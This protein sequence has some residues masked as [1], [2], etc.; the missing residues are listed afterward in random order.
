[1]LEKFNILVVDDYLDNRYL[2]SQFLD[3]I[4]VKHSE[5]TN[6][7]ECLEKLKSQQFDLIFMDIEMPV[8]NG[9]ETTRYIRENF[10]GM[11][12]QIPII[13]ITAHAGYEFESK[14]KTIGF[15]DFVSK[16]YSMP[17]LKAILEKHLL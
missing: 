12:A 14:I 1:M 6:G 15:N 5:V 4:G 3:I 2:L 10:S 11:Q 16:P 13:A 8:M 7:K 9:Y 17:K